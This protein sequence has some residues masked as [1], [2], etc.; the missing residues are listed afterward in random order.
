MRLSDILGQKYFLVW[1]KY[2]VGKV[3]RVQSLMQNKQK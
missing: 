2:G 3:K 1:R